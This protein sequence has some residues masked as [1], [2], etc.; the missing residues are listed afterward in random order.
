[1]SLS[2]AQMKDAHW[3]YAYTRTADMAQGSTYDNVIT[4]IKGKGIL[5]N[6]RRGYIDITRASRHVKL[7]TDNPEK[8]LISWMNNDTNKSS[9]LET[10]DKHYPEQAPWF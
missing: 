2:T 10:R 5:T 7:I 1:L 9:A 4:T 3:D 6:I 8:M